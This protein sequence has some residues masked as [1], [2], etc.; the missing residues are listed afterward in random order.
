MSIEGME[1]LARMTDSKIKLRSIIDK[2]LLITYDL[3]NNEAGDKARAEFLIKASAVGATRH[4]DSVYLM[5]WSPEAETLALE[6][7]K[8]EGGEVIAWAQA[9]PLNHKEDITAGYDAA[10]K[11]IMKE[12]S[13]RLDKMMSY[14]HDNHQKRVIQMIPKTERLLQNAEAAVTRRGSEVL[15][16]WLELLKQRY[17][18]TVGGI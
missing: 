7:A 8:T 12:I 11:P 9:E 2:W 10:L 15:A 16:I 13:A 5:P 4:T 1:V 17:Q 14:R 6:L 18:Q 3:P